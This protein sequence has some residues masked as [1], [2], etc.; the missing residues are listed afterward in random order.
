MAAA[1]LRRLQPF[2]PAWYQ[3]G[4]SK[5]MATLKELKVRL[6]SV[7]NMEKIT[8]SMKMVS[9][10]K[11][12]HS[13]RALR[14]AR[15]YGQ[16]A[17]ALFEKAE[18]VTDERKPNHLI[19][20]ISSDRGLCG[21]IHSNVG[22]SI[23]ATMAERAADSTTNVVCV[24]DK[25]RTIMQ[26]YYRK[27]ILLNFT[28]VG[29]KPPVFSEAS[30]IAQQIL[31]TGIEFESA[32]IVYNWFRNVISYRTKSQFLVPYSTLSTS[33]KMLLYD[34]VDTDLLQCYHEMALANL[35]FYAMKE[36][37]CSELSARMTAMDSASKNAGD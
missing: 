17:M 20:A 7:Q 22:K 21:G 9:A 25:I 24:G 13:E 14:P 34:E 3:Y 2:R 28:N 31:S 5:G 23:R 6:K 30:F 10:A 12:T 27:N 1:V 8:K 4:G 35:I 18:V 11:F 32:E 26:R 15:T 16:G 37:A 19:I 36:G 29:K 33:E